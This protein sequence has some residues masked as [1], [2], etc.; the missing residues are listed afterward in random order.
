MHTRYPI[1]YV[2][3]TLQCVESLRATLSEVVI[4]MQMTAQARMLV[5]TRLDLAVPDV[6]FRS[7]CAGA[8]VCEPAT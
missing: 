4:A 1:E 8:G 7:R 2:I 5:C 6:V 3:V